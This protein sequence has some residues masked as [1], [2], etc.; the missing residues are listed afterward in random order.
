MKIKERPD[1]TRELKRLA[2]R[3]RSE[4][5][6]GFPWF[7]FGCL[8]SAPTAGA[9]RLS[10]LGPD[11]DLSLRD[12][13]HKRNKG[14]LVFWGQD[15]G[16]LLDLSQQAAGVPAWRHDQLVP[17]SISAAAK[18][19]TVVSTGSFVDARGPESGLKRP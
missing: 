4:G 19:Q 16:R 12:S 7:V 13:G 5:L 9:Q 6:V 10:S 15:E 2:Q 11:L 1:S 18:P 3:L 14:R 8:L 17:A